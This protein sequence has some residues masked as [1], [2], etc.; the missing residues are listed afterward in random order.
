MVVSM[1]DDPELRA[2]CLSLGAQELIV[3]PAELET[4]MGH[5]HKVAL[6]IAHSLFEKMGSD[7]ATVASPGVA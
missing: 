2:L 7:M 4:L 3:K 5:I 1:V 6:Q